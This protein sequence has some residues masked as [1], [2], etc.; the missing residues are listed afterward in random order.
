M[1]KVGVRRERALL[2]LRRAEMDGAEYFAVLREN[3][4]AVSDSLAGV[5]C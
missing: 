5:I 3:D 4:A 1:L 2:G